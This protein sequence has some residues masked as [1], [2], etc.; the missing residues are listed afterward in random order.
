MYGYI[1]RHKI[2]RY[3]ILEMSGSGIILP[4]ILLS[5]Y[6]E[7]VKGVTADVSRKIFTD[8]EN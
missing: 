4:K 7:N 6:S 2:L 8:Y 5:K 1:T 3:Y